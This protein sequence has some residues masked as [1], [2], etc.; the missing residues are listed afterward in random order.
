MKDVGRLVT[1]FLLTALLCGPVLVA[2][3]TQVPDLCAP[4][5]CPTP[6]EFVRAWA[7]GV[8]GDGTWE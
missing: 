8:V 7:V 4:E 3:S 5:G 2:S 6:V 1:G